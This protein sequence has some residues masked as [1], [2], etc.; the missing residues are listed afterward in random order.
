SERRHG[1]ARGVHGECERD[2]QGDA[3]RHVRAAEMTTGRTRQS[4]R[5]GASGGLTG[6]LR[7]ALAT[8]GAQ[9]AIPFK[10]VFADGSEYANHGADPAFTLR[11]NSRRAE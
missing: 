2:R 4:G 8:M 7:R 6:A 11:F 9:T 3:D 1:V 5:A 10:V